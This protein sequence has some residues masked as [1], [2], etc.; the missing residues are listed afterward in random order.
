M[1]N[2]V[3]LNN[4]RATAGAIPGRGKSIRRRTQFWNCV[5]FAFAAG[6]TT[7]WLCPTCHA[8]PF[9]G[10]YT[11][12][13]THSPANPIVE[14]PCPD[15]DDASNGSS[16][17]N[18]EATT[19]SVQSPYQSSNPI[20][21][22]WGSAHESGDDLTLSAPGMTW[23]LNRGYTNGAATA[24]GSTTQGN[25]WMNNSSD[26]FIYGNPSSLLH[27]ALDAASQREF[28]PSGGGFVLNSPQRQLFSSDGK[29][30]EPSV[31]LYRPDAEYPLGIQ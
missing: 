19:N 2:M 14:P 1:S 23:T 22:F 8:W 7:L 3:V 20:M 31:H 4:Q 21:Y 30:D 12:T 29:R 18:S 15:C 5:R 26:R 9:G 28:V 25:N 16:L 13:C 27:V 24:G 6:L 10:C 17:G 11:F